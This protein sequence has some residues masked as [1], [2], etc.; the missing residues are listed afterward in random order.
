M[1][2]VSISEHQ[3]VGHLFASAAAAVLVVADGDV[4]IVSKHSAQE[5]TAGAADAGR[6][7]HG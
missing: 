5:T 6:D 4:L 3:M 7:H 2:A 1:Y